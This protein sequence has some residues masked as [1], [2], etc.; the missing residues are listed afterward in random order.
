[1]GIGLVTQFGIA[2]ESTFGTAVTVDKFH[3]IQRETLKRN[4]P[5]RVPTAGLR[6][7]GVNVM[8][9]GPVPTQSAAGDVEMLVQTTGMGRYFKQ[10]VGGTPT[11][12]QQGGTPAY[13]E[14][15]NLGTLAAKSLTLQKGIEEAAGTVRPFTYPGSKLLSGTFACAID[16]ALRLTMT[17]D[18]R[19]E[20]T[21]T[22]L[23]TASYSTPK[24][25]HFGQ[26]NLKFAGSAVASVTAADLTI[27]RNLK[28][29]SFYFNAGGL[30]GEQR[31]NDFPAVT[32]NVTAEFTDR[33]AFYDRFA[34]DTAFA[35]VLEF[36]GD[37]ISGIYSELLRITVPEV[38][39]IGETPSADGPDVV[40]TTCPWEAFY[41]GTNAGVKIEYVTTDT[42]I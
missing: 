14:T 28:T 26:A 38:R 16:E 18:C 13:L 34:A 39:L 22:S 10:L 41:D 17:F 37:V 35:L 32:G 5:N 19:K 30:K 12:A 27:A 31:E 4:P 25:F 36:T 7:G 6:A 24:F 9:A 33:T 40:T 20:E 42:S 29:D 21:S 2:E 23:A 3:E 1:M 15:F 11:N 8:R